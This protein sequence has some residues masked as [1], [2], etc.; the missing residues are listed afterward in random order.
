M[1]AA[2]T[3]KLGFRR[4]PSFSETGV[5]GSCTLKQLSE[6]EITVYRRH[7]PQ[8]KQD[9]RS[10][11]QAR[12]GRDKYHSSPGLPCCLRVSQLSERLSSRCVRRTILQSGAVR[13]GNQDLSAGFSVPT[14]PPGRRGGLTPSAPHPTAVLGLRRKPSS[15]NSAQ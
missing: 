7:R 8:K 1:R 2:K 5:S 12:L 4:N 13:S 11:R 6:D 3:D 15:E 10:K 9:N 14:H